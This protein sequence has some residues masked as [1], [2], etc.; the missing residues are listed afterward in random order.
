MRG[1]IGR[2]A[3]HS[4][5]AGRRTAKAWLANPLRQDLD[6]GSALG[7]KFGAL[8][9]LDSSCPQDAA[10]LIDQQG[11]A[12]AVEAR[13]MASLEEA[14]QAHRRA[15]PKGPEAVTGPAA[16]EEHLTMNRSCVEQG[17]Q[18]TAVTWGRVEWG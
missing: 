16:A 6:A 2:H 15:C 12:V 18:P 7:P 17:T 14:P 3:Q 5:H 8:G 11:Q 4:M 1:Q 10:A 9:D 13:H